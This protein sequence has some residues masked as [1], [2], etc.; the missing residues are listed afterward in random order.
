M[1]NLKNEQRITETQCNARL[2]SMADALYAI[3]G[4]WKLRIIVALID[5]TKRF[6]E[7]QRMLDGI[8]AKV[9]SNELKDL[10]LN[11]FVKRNVYTGMPVIVEYE[12]TEYSNTLEHVLQALSEWG[13]KHREKIKRSL[14]DVEAVQN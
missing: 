7:L 13:A 14:H 8:S 1:Q 9:L 3:G 11:G 4:K 10:E 12:L 2:A 6:N 5:G